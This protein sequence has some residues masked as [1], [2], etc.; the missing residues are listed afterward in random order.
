VIS[1]AFSAL[2]LYG[3]YA[4]LTLSNVK[5]LAGN[6]AQSN[7]RDSA[8]IDG[9]VELSFYFSKIDSNMVDFTVEGLKLPFGLINSASSSSV[10][11]Q[12]I[13]MVASA[14]KID[15]GRIQLNRIVFDG[16]FYI[17]ALR[18]ISPLN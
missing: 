8:S 6:L 3:K 4:V 13:S 14:L 15:T 11:D 5:D 2:D 18:I 17:V 10:E 1:R 16:G 7:L 12:A 9:Q